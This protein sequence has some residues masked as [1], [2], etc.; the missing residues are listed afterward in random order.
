MRRSHIAVRYRFVSILLTIMIMTSSY[1]IWSGNDVAEAIPSDDIRATIDVQFGKRGEDFYTY[2]TE[3]Y[4]TISVSYSGFV[5]SS[6]SIAPGELKIRIPTNIIKDGNG[7][8]AQSGFIIHDSNTYYDNNYDETVHSLEYI[9]NYEG[10]TSELAGALYYYTDSEDENS[11]IITN[12][13]EIP[14]DPE[15]DFTYYQIMLR[16]EYTA[17]LPAYFYSA[18]VP[19]DP[20]YMDVSLAKGDTVYTPSLPTAYTYSDAYTCE[21][22]GFYAEDYL[23]VL[24]LDNSTLEATRLYIDAKLLLKGQT[25]SYG[26]T[27]INSIKIGS[28]TYTLGDKFRLLNDTEREFLSNSGINVNEYTYTTK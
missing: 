14:V 8:Y 10:D 7:N 26:V 21:G 17:S 1:N 12:F 22:G 27:G 23:P 6:E 25:I 4:Q 2:L 16:V 5:N 28:I 3:D 11:C 24:Y 18:E 13:K 15:Y 9:E 20:L 19:T